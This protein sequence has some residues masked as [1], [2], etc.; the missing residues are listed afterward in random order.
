M[1]SIIRVATC[2]AVLGAATSAHAQQGNSPFFVGLQV[3]QALGSEVKFKQ[4][5][6]VDAG[7]EKQE[8]KAGIGFGLIAG[9]RVGSNMALYGTITQSNQDL[10]NSTDDVNY[11]HLGIGGRYL[12]T[13]PSPNF[14]PYVSAEV[15]QRSYS[16][17]SCDAGCV[18]FTLTGM[19]F[20]GG[21]G[22]R[23]AFQPNWSLDASL[24][25]SY[26]SYKDY[27]FGTFNGDVKT[28][29]SLGTRVNVG[30]TWMPGT[31]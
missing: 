19:Y 20:G 29:S 16:G 23:Y 10:K 6:G 5:D 4:I 3:T 7:G 28:S 12:M 22:G 21:L 18:D 14:F 17:E 2:V 11:R 15:G 13:H 9:Y 27:E 25:L 31:Q 26:G 30:V 24:N 8:T 1:R